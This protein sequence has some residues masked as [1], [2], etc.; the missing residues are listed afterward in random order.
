MEFTVCRGNVPAEEDLYC[1]YTSPDV[2]SGDIKEDLRGGSVAHRILM[3][4]L[5]EMDPYIDLDIDGE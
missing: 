4:N 3:E 2:V 1:S 5:K